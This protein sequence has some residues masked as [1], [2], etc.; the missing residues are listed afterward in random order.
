MNRTEI[1]FTIVAITLIVIG[2]VLL[3][4]A[5]KRKRDSPAISTGPEGM[6]MYASTRLYSP[7]SPGYW[8][9]PNA[10]LNNLADLIKKQ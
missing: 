6:N 10:K 3:V 2:I 1:I 8:D 9:N 5:P 7:D 4:V